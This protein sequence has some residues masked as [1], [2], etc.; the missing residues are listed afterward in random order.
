[1]R[2]D[3]FQRANEGENFEW[4]VER[5]FHIS[6]LSFIVYVLSSKQESVFFTQ[7]NKV[8]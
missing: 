3:F 1:M 6:H 4:Q 2:S 7:S 8:K 5:T